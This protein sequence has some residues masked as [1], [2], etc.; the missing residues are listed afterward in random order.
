MHSD[1]AERKARWPR[2]KKFMENLGL[3]F[4]GDGLRATLARTVF[5]GA[6]FQLANVALMFLI[7]V[8]LARGLGPAGYGI[9]A[10]ALASVSLL[11]IVT[12][13]GFPQVALRETSIATATQDWGL[14]RGIAIFGPLSVGVTSVVMLVATELFFRF[15]SLKI[16]P[17][18]R[19]TLELGLLL[20]P[21]VAQAKISSYMLMGLQRILIG[22]FGNLVLRPGSF[23]LLIALVVVWRGGLTPLQ[24]MGLQVAGT[25]LTLVF[26]VSSFLALLPSEAR[27]ATARIQTHNWLAAAWPMAMTEGLRVAQGQLSV[28]L[29][30]ALSTAAQTGLFR[31]ADST[32]TM[33]GV[34]VSLLNSIVISM[35]A[36][37]WAKRDLGRLQMLAS[38]TTIAVMAGA[39]AL[40]VPVALFG[41]PL[42]RLFFGTSFGAAYPTFLISCLANCSY[43]IFGLAGSLL[44]MSG[45]ERQVTKAI[46]ISLAVSVSLAIL[47][48]PFWGGRGAAMANVTGAFVWT[49]LSWRNARSRLGIDTSLMKSFSMWREGTLRLLPCP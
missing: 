4:S 24:A 13:F 10:F 1:D 5:G 33:C 28:V 49:I 11:G 45:N 16:D 21:L 43:G 48:I 31:V 34:T 26:A 39:V 15:S 46:A 27:R 18:S 35:F 42:F 14:L 41:R 3:N 20:I 9:Y 7:G 2:I 22:Q 19:Q 30:G 37:L 17:V 36:S 47:V 8:Q 44:N 6:F 32:A 38:V 25:F 23:A 29:L 12:E 40:S